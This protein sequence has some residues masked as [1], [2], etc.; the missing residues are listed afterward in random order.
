[1]PPELREKLKRQDQLSRLYQEMCSYTVRCPINKCEL[2]DGPMGVIVEV[3]PDYPT[4]L[5]WEC[6]FCKGR[7]HK[8]LPNHPYRARAAAYVGAA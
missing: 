8:W 4:V 5:Y 1:M 7:W 2:R 6:K 3:E